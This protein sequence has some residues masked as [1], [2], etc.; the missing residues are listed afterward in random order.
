VGPRGRQAPSIEGKLEASSS[1][2]PPRLYQP[3]GLVAKASLWLP[4][5][6][7]REL[8]SLLEKSQ[9]FNRKVLEASSGLAAKK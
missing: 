4:F 7:K 8:A 3:C 1:L 6:V 9:E 2:P 5:R